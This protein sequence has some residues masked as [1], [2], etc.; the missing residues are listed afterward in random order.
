MFLVHFEANTVYA[1]F[2]DLSKESDK[3]ISKKI[4][5]QLKDQDVP[6]SIHQRIKD[7]FTD[8]KV[9]ESNFS[10]QKAYISTLETYIDVVSDKQKKNTYRLNLYILPK[11]V[12]ITFCKLSK[13]AT[14][15]QIEIK[16]KI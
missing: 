15:N 13:I 10:R 5:N 2:Q 9:I 3:K 8:N 6:L 12:N 16:L 14:I 11:D 4:I 7:F 1:V